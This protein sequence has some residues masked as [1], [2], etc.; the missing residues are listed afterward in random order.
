M[1]VRDDDET[2]VA[3]RESAAELERMVIALDEAKRK[4]GAAEAALREG[5]APDLRSAVEPLLPELGRPA[6][7]VGPD[8]AIL[9]RSVGAEVPVDLDLHAV[10]DAAGRAAPEVVAV[11]SVRA[12]AVGPA[13]GLV[14]VL[15]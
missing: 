7:V 1:A 6:V 13:H 15:L 5:A 14:V 9:A 3:L 10:M 12:V 4:L 8:L 11:G 2:T